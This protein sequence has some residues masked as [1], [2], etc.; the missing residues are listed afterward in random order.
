M[1]CHKM[2]TLKSQIAIWLCHKFVDM[3]Y[4]KVLLLLFFQEASFK[5]RRNLVRGLGQDPKNFHAELRSA[6][7]TFYGGGVF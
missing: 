2:V 7:L 4:D 6:F 5:E 3:F 1:F